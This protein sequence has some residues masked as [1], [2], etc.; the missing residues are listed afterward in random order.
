[1]LHWYS[2]TPHPIMVAATLI[3]ILFSSK[4]GGAVFSPQMVLKSQFHFSLW[5]CFDQF[6]F[7]A[8]SLQRKTKLMFSVRDAVTT[9]NNT[10][11]L[12]SSSG[13]L[14]PSF[15]YLIKTKNV[16]LITNIHSVFELSSQLW[17]S[18]TWYT[19]VTVLSRISGNALNNSWYYTGV[20][21]LWFHSYP[22]S[23]QS[24]WFHSCLAST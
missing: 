19:S 17:V 22:S 21:V 16:W 2:E 24:S 13:M 18:A 4:L 14:C 10:E 23:R 12:C 6:T 15:L 20:C 1:M 3:L 8:F 7:S 9:L 11:F 5:W